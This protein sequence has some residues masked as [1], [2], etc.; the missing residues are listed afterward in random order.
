MQG[1]FDR[2]GRQH[3][4]LRVSITDRCNFR[5]TYCMPADG[6]ECQP[7][8]NL[9]SFEEIA[10]LVR[11]FV[12]HGVRK[13]RLTGG[14]P[15]VRREYLELVER[16]TQIEG[17]PEVAITTNGSRLALDAE[18]LYA[19]RIAG[20]NVSLDTLDAMRF[21]KITRR[22]KFSLVWD[23]IQEALRVGLKLKV[24]CVVMPGVNDDEVLDFVE[25]ARSQ[26]LTVRFIEFMPFLDNSWNISGVVSSSEIREKIGEKFQLFPVATAPGQVASS[27][28]I[29]GF[30]G[31]VEFVSSVTESFCGD[32]NR[33]RLTADG[34]VKSCLFLPAEISLRDLLRGDASEAELLSAV[35]NCLDGKWKEHPPMTKWTQLDQLTMVQIGG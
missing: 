22:D 27:Y 2:Y 20:V 35:Q 6:I 10:S 30:R 3:T 11:F 7:K 31:E 14:E 33:L 32:C 23:G 18:R 26:P 16:L 4:Y 15:T 19:L 34:L 13:V 24:N 9:L 21:E 28:Q 8:E 25:L 29:P 17:L 1:L 12:R 5:C